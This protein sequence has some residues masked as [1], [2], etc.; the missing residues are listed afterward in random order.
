MKMAVDRQDVNSQLNLLY[1][2]YTLMRGRKIPTTQE[3][4]GRTP[5]N[6]RGM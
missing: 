6:H 4:K 5:R 2:T 1:L 3:E